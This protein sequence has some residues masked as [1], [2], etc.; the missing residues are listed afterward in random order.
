MNSRD[1]EGFNP[2]AGIR[3]FLT[4]QILWVTDGR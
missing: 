1:Q 2:L 3:C 4:P